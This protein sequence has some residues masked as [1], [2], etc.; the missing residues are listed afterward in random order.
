MNRR[1]MTLRAWRFGLAFGL[2]AGATTVVS[3]ASAGSFND[4]GSYAFDPL[5]IERFD[6]EDDGPEWI[7]PSDPPP[8]TVV[9]ESAL[10]GDHVLQLES[11]N[12]FAT[13]RWAIVL[14]AAK[15]SFGVSA[16][17]RGAEANLSLRFTHEGS[18]RFDEVAMLF[19]TG[20]ITSDGWVEVAADGVRVDGKR[21]RVIINAFCS[22]CEIDAVEV[23]IEGT[24]DTDVNTP[25][26]GATDAQSCSTGQICMWGECRNV[27]GWVPPIPAERELVTQYLERRLRFLFG[28]YLERKQDMPATLSALE[29]MRAAT[30]RWS[31]WNSFFVAVR[32]LHDGH[33][34]AS[35][36]TPSFVIGNPRPIHACFIEG[37]AD[38]S[39]GVA[40]SDSLYRD[41]LVSHVGPDHNLGL[42]AGDRLVRVDGMHPI[43]WARSLL[44]VHAGYRPAS[45]HRT[46]AEQASDLRSTIARF[47][48]EL[49]V[50]RCDSQQQSCGA[51]ET[52]D[53]SAIA[54]DEPGTT[55]TFVAC[56]S[57]PLRHIP[58][59]PTV[60][61]SAGYY[62]VFAG[63]LNESDGSEKVYGVAW[64]AL[65]TTDGNNGVG[66]NL[67]AAIKLL[68]DD[69]ANGVIFDHRTGNGGTLLGPKPIW[70][71]AVASHPITFMQT[72][73]RAGDERPDTTAGTSIFQTALSSGLVDWAGSNS[74][75]TI[76]I[77]LLITNDVSASDWLPLGMKNV[78][79]N[80][81]I[82]GPYETSG[83]FSTLYTLGYW[84]GP[85]Y[86]MASA[87]SFDPDGNTL[88]GTGVQPD[89]VTMPLQSDLVVGKDTVFE[90]ALAWIRQELGS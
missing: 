79:P 10:S 8:A 81:R 58:G 61:H 50:V 54:F 26:A 59:A 60:S 88:N 85:Q 24:I 19:P 51:L 66:A 1:V 30:D 40:P 41:V 39:Q 47:A 45:N 57:R 25:C 2:A 4:N 82:F 49:Q 6:F 9:S 3:S 80:V 17:I 48:N 53:I 46:F 72:R 71:F 23:V 64:E 44:D 87:D 55:T 22:G 29:A 86:V 20:R 56:D 75:S 69:A 78:G 5:A 21:S 67:K 83:A 37:D 16:W 68:K 15:R 63:L 43:A 73:R 18:Y 62:D 77:A 28:P 52:I 12:G 7:D 76:P 36:S 35:A 31:Y 90:A 11:P 33:T 74:P 38:L 27:S 14:P 70:D 84:G 65:G 34:S 89:V 13:A 42:K 32:R